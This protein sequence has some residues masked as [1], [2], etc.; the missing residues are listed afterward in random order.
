MLAELIDQS[1]KTGAT[2]GPKIAV[3]VIG[4]NEGLRLER[5][6]RSIPPGLPAIYVDSGSTDESVSF[7]RSLGLAVIE[8]DMTVGFTAARARNVGWRALNSDGAQPALVQFVDGDCEL[9]PG[10]IAAATAALDSEPAVA[11]VFGRR[12]E[13]FPERSLF[14]RM[15]DE[16]WNVPIGLVNACGGDAMI[17]MTAL[18]QVDGYADDLIAGEEPDL[19][20][21][22]RRAG[23]LVRRIDAEMTLHDANILSLASWWRRTRRGGFAY[24]AHVLR[25][26]GHADPQWRRQIFS[27]AFWG[28][29]WPGSGLVLSLTLGI[30]LNGTLGLAAA[31][32]IAFS[33]CV[34]ILRIAY[35]RARFGTKPAVALQYG[36]LVMLAK[37]AEMGGVIRCLADRLA[38]RTSG[39]IEY[40]GKS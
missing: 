17:R 3:V 22:L 5:C 33:Y 21:R 8:L 4:R 10:W 12:R 35:R 27:I 1:A 20:L 6:L 38:N 24:A 18:K 23:W 9:D 31:T 34:Q 13:R 40:K 29:L 16:E 37:F 15:C 11:V 25:H 26:R 28:C 36:A 19:C 30:L 7:A 32:L 14:N 2:A 39:I